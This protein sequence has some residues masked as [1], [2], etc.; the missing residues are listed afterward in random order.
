MLFFLFILHM[1]YYVCWIRGMISFVIF[2]NIVSV[3]ISFFRLQDSS[4]Y[5]LDICIFSSFVSLCFILLLRWG[6]IIPESW[7]IFWKLLPVVRPFRIPASSLFLVGSESWLFFLWA[8]WVLRT[9][10][11]LLSF[12]V[13]S[14]MSKFPKENPENQGSSLWIFFLGVSTT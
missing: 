9:C 12:S 5:V 1:V 11:Y 13:T 14:S 2:S 7:A 8:L 4:L 6:E 3:P 10:V